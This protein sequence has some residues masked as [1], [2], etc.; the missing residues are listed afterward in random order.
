M[1]TSVKELEKIIKEEVG[2]VIQEQAGGQQRI[3]PMLD[4]ISTAYNAFLVA[5]K[6]RIK[7]NLGPKNLFFQSSNA[8]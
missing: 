7:E 2:A 1:K 8:R 5:L 3:K 6:K 4:G